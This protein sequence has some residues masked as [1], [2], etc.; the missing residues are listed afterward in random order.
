MTTKWLSNS[1]W[2]TLAKL[3]LQEAS[4][5]KFS[6]KL[7]SKG[8]FWRISCANDVQAWL[9]F[10]TLIG[11]RLKCYQE[12]CV[13]IKFTCFCWRD[14]EHHYV[15]KHFKSLIG[16]HKSS[17]LLFPFISFTLMWK[18]HD[19]KISFAPSSS[20]WRKKHFCWRRTHHKSFF[21]LRL[22]QHIS[23]CED[24]R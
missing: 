13:F 15:D 14:I 4:L 11:F 5:R 17:Y 23:T 6:R 2:L 1:L 19:I 12:L 18:S 9:I 24:R 22:V 3:H 7:N 21:L 8:D 20:C 16:T 10:Y